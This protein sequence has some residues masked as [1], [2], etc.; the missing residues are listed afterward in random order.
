MP[1]RQ[2][3][4][5]QGSNIETNLLNFKKKES[6]IKGC[7]SLIVDITTKIVEALKNLRF[8]MDIKAEY[9]QTKR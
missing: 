5:C 4:P 8:F 7:T 6:N 9:S 1:I 3:R 2:T